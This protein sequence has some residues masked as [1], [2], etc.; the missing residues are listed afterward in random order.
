M[1]QKV[2]AAVRE[3]RERKIGMEKEPQTAVNIP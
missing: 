3:S 2:F 1:A